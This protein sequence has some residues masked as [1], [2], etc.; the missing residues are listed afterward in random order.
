[1]TLDPRAKQLAELL[2]SYSVNLNSKDTLLIHSEYYFHE[3]VDELTSQAEK[4]GA[5]VLRDYCTYDNMFARKLI[6]RNDPK[7][8]RDE[9]E[10]R[11]DLASKCTARIWVD[12]TGYDE[13][14]KGISTDKLAEYQ[15]KLMAPFK[16]VLYRENAQGETIVKW[17]ITGYPSEVN[18]KVAGMSYA[19]FSD[20]VYG[21]TLID[22]DK[23][24][25]EMVKVKSVFDNAK[26][27]TIE[28][29]F[30]NNLKFS[31]ASRKG[32]VCSATHNMPS[33]EVYFAPEEDSVNGKIRFQVPS[34]RD[35]VI[36]KN[37]E[38]V[39]ED[40]KVVSAF[41]E[42][43]NDF[44]QSMLTMKGAKGV[45]EFG[46]GCNYG[47]TRPTTNLIFDEKIGGTIHLALG[48]CLSSNLD[49]GGGFNQSDLHWDL[50]SDLRSSGN[51]LTDN[52]NSINVN[53]GNN[54]GRIY[55]D[56]GVN[57]KLVQENGIWVFK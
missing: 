43:N 54:G 22:W 55:V 4:K 34:E 47:I 46:I 39:L 42:Q 51:F 26:S 31:L 38:M 53:A 11:N 40:G 24:T 50:V 23:L 32:H 16:R 3:F 1:M 28:D 27:V 41:A 21:A 13:P 12:A 44:L 45:G 36:L 7:E 37:I 8:W 52:T 29:S 14:L 5:K 19:D 56:D 48:Y 35:G 25:S 9:L 20:F 30:G 10:R 6:E 15:T 49:D 17:N 33:G 2:L 18:A 57:N